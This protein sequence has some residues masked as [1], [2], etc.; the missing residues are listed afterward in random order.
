MLDHPR[1]DDQ[2]QVVGRAVLV[3]D[4]SLERHPQSVGQHA[5]VL[6]SGLGGRLSREAVAKGQDQMGGHAREAAAVAAVAA[7]LL[8]LARVK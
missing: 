7:V 5:S 6:P 1:A 2:V 8:A 4:T 3:V